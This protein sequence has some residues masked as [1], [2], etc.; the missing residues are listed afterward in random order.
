MTGL[1]D[2]GKQATAQDG[3]WPPNLEH[4]AYRASIIFHF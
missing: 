4:R 1:E 3:T 2:D